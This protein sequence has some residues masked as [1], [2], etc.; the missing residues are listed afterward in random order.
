MNDSDGKTGWRAGWERH[1]FTGEAAELVVD[2][3]LVHAVQ[4]HWA[5][6]PN[7][8]AMIRSDGTSIANTQL[9]QMVFGAAAQ[10][11]ELGIGI[12]DNVLM[13]CD[14]SV[15]LVVA[16]LAVL[17]IGAVAV[18]VNTVSMDPCVGAGT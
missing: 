9:Q 11:V 17:M 16:H 4:Q 6:D 3:T 2:R 13:S 5:T 18:P 12:G 15:E 14:P 10:L 8:V 7:R 1:N